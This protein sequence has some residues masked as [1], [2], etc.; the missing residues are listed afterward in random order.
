[1]IS[2]DLCLNIPLNFIADT[3]MHKVKEILSDGGILELYIP[4]QKGHAGADL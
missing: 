4:D 3:H 2:F 1:M